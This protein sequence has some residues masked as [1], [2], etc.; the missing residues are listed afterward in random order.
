VAVSTPLRIDSLTVVVMIP[1][2]FRCGPAPGAQGWW[3]A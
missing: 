1:V 3:Y 2:S